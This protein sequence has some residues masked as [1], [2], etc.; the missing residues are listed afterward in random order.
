MYNRWMIDDDKQCAEF[1]A[2]T[3]FQALQKYLATIGKE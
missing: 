3:L 2:R 1:V